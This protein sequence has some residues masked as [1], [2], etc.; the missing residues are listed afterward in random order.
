MLIRDFDNNPY[1]TGANV[2]LKPM[3]DP[4]RLDISEQRLRRLTKEGDFDDLEVNDFLTL[5]RNTYAVRTAEGWDFY[6]AKGF[7]EGGEE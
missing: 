5:S 2:W 4:K 1:I 3:T 7:S 6:E